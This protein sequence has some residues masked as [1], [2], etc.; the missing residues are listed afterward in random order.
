MTGFLGVGAFETCSA[1][2]RAVNCRSYGGHPPQ[3]R[4]FWGGFFFLENRKLYEWQIGLVSAVLRFPV[5]LLEGIGV[6]RSFS[7][8]LDFTERNEPPAARKSN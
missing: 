6:S 2:P 1:A 3:Q 8:I 5:R 7:E 4:F